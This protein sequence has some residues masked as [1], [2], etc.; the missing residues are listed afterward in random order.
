[1]CPAL[2]DAPGFMIAGSLGAYAAKTAHDHG[3]GGGVAAGG[4]T[5]GAGGRMGWP[6]RSRGWALWAGGLGEAVE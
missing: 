5:H 3:R 6:A 4:R 1:M 2:R